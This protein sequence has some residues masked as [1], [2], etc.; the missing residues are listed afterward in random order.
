M[1][2]KPGV[3]RVPG[4]GAL[5]TPAHGLPKATPREGTPVRPPGA[6]VPPGAPNRP[7][8][9][10]PP[11][12]EGPPSVWGKPPAAPPAA[13]PRPAAA[14]PAAGS[15]AAP[16]EPAPPWPGGAGNALVGD[17][18]WAG[19]PEAQ[20][21]Y[22]RRE[23]RSSTTGPMGVRETSG[24]QVRLG[25]R[26]RARERARERRANGGAGRRSGLVAA[27]VLVLAALVTAG[28]VLTPGSGDDGGTGTGTAPSGGE[29][30]PA[31]TGEL[32]TAGKPITV[33][34]ADGSQYKI[35]AVSDGVS[36]GLETASQSPPSGTSFAYIEYILSNPTQKQVLLDFPGD[37]FVKRN[38]IAANARGRC[39]PQA[40]VPE[41][42]CTPPTKSQV[43]RHLSGGALVAGDGGDKYMPPGSAFLVR[44]TVD[45]PVDRGIKRSD[46]GLYVWKQL[47]MADQLAKQAPFPRKE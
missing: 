27:G 36:G 28:L 3:P 35:A 2:T 44:A 32:P 20:E 39:M 21:A 31:G 18:E 47:Y 17:A 16:V 13:V 24:V 12:A 25:P 29:Q 10:T 34:T 7:I 41:D 23:E 6:P 37:V 30:P 38:L 40:G 42:M 26:E 45:V 5:H 4:G 22:S 14:P 1:D 15:P 9:R 46:M 8:V 43:V 19:V 33:G 11:A